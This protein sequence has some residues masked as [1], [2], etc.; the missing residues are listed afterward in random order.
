MIHLAIICAEHLL[1]VRHDAYKGSFVPSNS[2]RKGT[3]AQ[4]DELAQFV[5]QR[6][7]SYAAL[8]LHDDSP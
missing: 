7:D 5:R 8:S 2:M 3:G 4:K 1:C 6:Q